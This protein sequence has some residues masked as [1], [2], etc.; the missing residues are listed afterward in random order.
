MTF[1]FHTLHQYKCRIAVSCIEGSTRW[2]TD[3]TYIGS[4]ISTGCIDCRDPAGDSAIGGSLL[5]GG[6]AILNHQTGVVKPG[7]VRKRECRGCAAEGEVI[8]NTDVGI[9][10]VSVYSHRNYGQKVR[11]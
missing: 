2:S 10:G 4:T 7:D 6:E 1:I 5:Y 8:V 11:P 9:P 3:S